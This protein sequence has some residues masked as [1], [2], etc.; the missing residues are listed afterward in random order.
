MRGN[1]E[2]KRFKGKAILRW[3]QNRIG[4]GEAKNE[5]ENRIG[6]SVGPNAELRLRSSGGE[7]EAVLWG[8]GTGDH[9][10]RPYG[11]GA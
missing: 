9:K 6:L 1:N 4:P 7:G 5:N 3:A 10:G 11:E 8:G 2:W